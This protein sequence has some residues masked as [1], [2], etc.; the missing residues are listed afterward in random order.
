MDTHEH[1]PYPRM[2]ALSTT[3]LGVITAIVYVAGFVMVA[4]WFATLQLN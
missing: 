1:E 3:V 4:A 2:P